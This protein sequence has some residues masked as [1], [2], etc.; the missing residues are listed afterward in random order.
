MRIVRSVKP[1]SHVSV[2]GRWRVSQPVSGRVASAP[3]FWGSGSRPR[4]S[5]SGSTYDHRAGRAHRRACAIFRV[6]AEQTA[7]VDAEVAGM[8]STVRDAKDPSLH[9]VLDD[10]AKP[11]K[12]WGCRSRRCRRRTWRS[13]GALDAFN[14]RRVD[15]LVSLSAEDCSG[16]RCERSSRASSIEDTKGSGSSSSDMD[17][18]WEEFRIDPLE[19][20]DRGE[21]VAVIGRVSALG[22]KRR[23]RSTRRGLRL[24]APARPDLAHHQS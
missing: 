13:C 19:F 11:S 21:R 8:Y 14:A 5:R 23:G 2:S 1:C 12:P 24:R 15:G 6:G 7:D 9:G 4:R 16:C 22:P 10:Q 3:G 20:H 17:E 18:D